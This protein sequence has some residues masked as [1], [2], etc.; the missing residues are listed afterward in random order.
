MP[1]DKLISVLEKLSDG[2]VKIDG[3]LSDLFGNEISVVDPNWLSN[4]KEKIIFLPL[5]FIPSLNDKYTYRFVYVI[6]SIHNATQLTN[7]K[8]KIKSNTYNKDL[9]EAFEKQERVAKLWLDQQPNLDVFY[10]N[11]I[12]DLENDIVKKFLF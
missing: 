1:G 11:S 6:E 5:N 10:I 8:M 7:R 4:F 2:G 12:N 9:M 3:D